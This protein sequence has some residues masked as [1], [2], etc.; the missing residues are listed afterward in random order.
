MVGAHGYLG[1]SHLTAAARESVSGW[2]GTR[3]RVEV[4]VVEPIEEPMVGDVVE[5]GG[6]AEAGD[7]AETGDTAEAGGAVAAGDTAGVGGAVE[8]G[9]VGGTAKGPGAKSKVWVVRG[10]Q[11]YHLNLPRRQTIRWSTNVVAQR[12]S[13]LAYLVGPLGWTDFHHWSRQVRPL[14]PLWVP[15]CP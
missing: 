3:E 13:I 15:I 4:G 10:V 8:A 14:L 9:A 5:T 7:T 1:N 6:V 2:E 12:S 11:D